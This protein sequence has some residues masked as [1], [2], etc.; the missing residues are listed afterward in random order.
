MLPLS[1]NI[2]LSQRNMPIDQIRRLTFLL[3]F[4]NGAG[5]L[6][7]DP[8]DQFSVLHR[9]IIH[10]DRTQLRSFFSAHRQTP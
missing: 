10:F 2:R 9:C 7:A 4:R 8:L 6:N 5:N 1:N 3:R